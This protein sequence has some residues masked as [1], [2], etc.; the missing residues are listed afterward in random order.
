MRTD[1]SL[2]AAAE[3][4]VKRWL[5][6]SYEEATKNEI[7]M[8]L[9]NDI[10]QV[11]ES[12]YTTLSFG[13]GGIRGLMGIGSNRVNIYTI[14]ELTQGLVN[15][16]KRQDVKKP[17]IVI[18]YDTRNN[19]RLFAEQA[20]KIASSNGVHAFL[21]DTCCPTPLLSFAVR[22]LSCMAGIMITASHNPAEY[23]GYKVYWS[24]G[25]QILS[26]HDKGI[27]KAIEEV[28]HEGLS[29][30][31]FQEEAE[32]TLVG[33]EIINSYLQETKKLMLWPA[34]DAKDN[35]K[36]LYSSLHGTGGVLMKD[37]F[38][39]WGMHNVG[40]VASQMVM[41]GNFPTTKTPNPESAQALKLGIDELME[42]EYD[43][44]L[45]TD[46]DA[47]RVGLVVRH[48]GKPY[49]L[50]GNQIASLMAEWICKRLYEEGRLPPR[51][52][53]VKTIVTTQLINHIA[54][55]WNVACFE[56]LTGFKYIAEKMRQWEE[57]KENGYSFVFG[58]E[59]SLGFLYGAHARDK[60]AIVSSCVIAEIAAH[61]KQHK[62]T[63]VDALHDLWK[64][65]GVFIE[66]L[67][68]VSFPETKEGRV[69]MGEC[70][71]AL[72]STPPS[73]FGTR[74]VV[75]FED[76][77][78]PKG[79]HPLPISDVLLFHLEGGGLLCIRPSGTE[80]KVKIYAMLS[81][82]Q[83]SSKDVEHF[84]ETEIISL[85]SEVVQ[86]LS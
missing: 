21:F 69:R 53:L 82:K 52:A 80:P 79:S 40:Y 81:E 1:L 43:I 50:T 20:A 7:R 67:K 5:N 16:M 29:R 66:R 3:K 28:R 24:D 22:K 61:F 39:L 6:D 37:A 14:R 9:Q 44:F 27:S 73:Q 46:P 48:H 59:E 8:L 56:V 42:K 74:K 4:N 71:G 2:S 12:F 23:N 68:T 65:Y 18:G 86:Y 17:S 47:D 57:N 72:R 34:D 41:D 10:Q 63:L 11:E 77:L 35:V 38:S 55:Y 51:P 60:D 84:L 33:S 70:M 85:L 31:I 26:P 54:K 13:T 62:K 64:K 45:A 32:Y 75:S 78:H 49:T 15:Y 30:I 83:S 58:G 76:L 25:A 36:I 19:S